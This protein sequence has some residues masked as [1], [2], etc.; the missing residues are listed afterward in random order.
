MAKAS[1][2]PEPRPAWAGIA[3]S[4]GN[5]NRGQFPGSGEPFEHVR[6]ARRL[7]DTSNLG[8]GRVREADARREPLDRQAETA[9]PPPEPTV[10][11]EKAQMQSGGRRDSHLNQIG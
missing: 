7:A 4:I 5:P 6:R 10:Q 2:V 9:E 3:A 1:C 8:R 11:V